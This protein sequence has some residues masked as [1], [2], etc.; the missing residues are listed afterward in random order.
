MA[1][2]DLTV[3]FFLAVFFFGTLAGADSV[4]AGIGAR[5]GLFASVSSLVDWAG[6]SGPVKL[7][8]WSAIM[9]E[10]SPLARKTDCP[11]HQI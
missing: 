3:S 5:G 4:C 7:P 8:S 9:K 6:G 2:D 10:I 1:F 11:Y